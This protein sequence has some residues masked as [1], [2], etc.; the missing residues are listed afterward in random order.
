MTG[1]DGYQPGRGGLCPRCEHARR[2]LERERRGTEDAGP[3]NGIMARLRAR[4]TDR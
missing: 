4:A 3:A 2:E 1:E